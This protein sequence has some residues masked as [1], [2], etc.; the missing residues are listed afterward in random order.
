VLR[1]GKPDAYRDSAAEAIQLAQIA[2]HWL[3]VLFVAGQY[4]TRERAHAYRTL[5][6][7]PDSFDQTLHLVHMRAGLLIFAV[8]RVRT[9]EACH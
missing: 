8:D 9:L 4:A 3:V 2:L 7:R 5:G 1:N 6:Q